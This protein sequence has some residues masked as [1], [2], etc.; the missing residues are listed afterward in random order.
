MKLLLT[1]A[2]LM[3]TVAAYATPKVGDT[4]EFALTMT[5]SGQT[6][7]GSFLTSI[8][9]EAG[10]QMTVATTVHFDGQPDQHQEES[11]AKAD[12]LTD[13]KIND[14]LANC[15]QYGG[16]LEALVVP[17]GTY[18]TCKLPSFDDAHKQNG[19]F[20]IGAVAFGI[21]KEEQTTADGTS[22]SLVLKTT[23]NGQ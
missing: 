6:R 5:Q 17:A 8:V 11:R 21:V 14:A 19:S 12:L 9:S 1:T 18:P 4:S 15:V 3:F 16:A 20:W 2:A 13:E 22:Y 7:V 23:K 10:D